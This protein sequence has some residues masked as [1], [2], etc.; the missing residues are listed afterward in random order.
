M[1][2]SVALQGLKAVQHTHALN[3]DPPNQ[4][5]IHRPYV[6]RMAHMVAPHGVVLL[7]S[8]EKSQGVHHHLQGMVAT[9]SH[10][11]LH[12][13]RFG[14]VVHPESNCLGVKGTPTRLKGMSFQ[15]QPD[16]AMWYP[17]L[18]VQLHCVQRG[19]RVTG[20]VEHFPQDGR[21]TIVRK[22]VG[23]ETGVSFIGGVGEVIY[24][25]VSDIK[26]MVEERK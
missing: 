9:E 11:G 8:G 5:R 14:G 3:G 20:G 17:M 4:A 6:L 1:C 24:G 2:H 22:E 23:N 21:E 25:R 26:I 10:Q 19:R 7:L 12:S 13:C 18:L 15:S 16:S